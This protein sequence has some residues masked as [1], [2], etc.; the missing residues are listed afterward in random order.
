MADD[1]TVLQAALTKMRVTPAL[2]EAD[3]LTHELAEARAE[4]ERLEDHLAKAGLDYQHAVAQ[5]SDLRAQLGAKAEECVE[6]GQWN[7]SLIEE[8]ERARRQ[9]AAKEQEC[10]RLKNEFAKN[11]H[12]KRQDTTL[13]AE[14]VEALEE[15]R[16][17]MPGSLRWGDL[18]AKA[19]SRQNAG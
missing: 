4:G 2:A 9:C 1:D 6:L 19:R 11:Y 8:A 3:R 14:L 7:E 5:A 10:E 16:E 12:H 18:L 17:P 15:A 13:I